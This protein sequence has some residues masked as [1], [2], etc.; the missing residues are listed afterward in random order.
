VLWKFI[1]VNSNDLSHIG[2]LA[3]AS[4]KKLEFVLNKPGAAS[5]SYPMNAD[6][7]A[8]IQPFKT[9]IKAMR[10]NRLASMIA[11]QAVWDC[12]WSGYVMPIDE[13]VDANKM[14]VSCVGWLNRL[15]KRLTRREMIFNA[16]DDGE[17][18]RQL[19]AEMNLTTAPDGYNVPIP[20][21]SSPNTPT[22]LSW[23]G[24]QPNE[25]AG[26]ATAYTTAS[27]NKTVA[28]YTPV[29]SV[30]DELCNIENGG[31]IV[32]DPLTR[33]VTWHRRY[34]RVKD[35]VV[36]GFQW[37]PQ[38][39][40]AFSRNIE[41]DSQINYIVVYGAPGTTPQYMDDKPQQSEIGL[42]E[43]NVS[44]ADVKD[45]NVLLAYAGAEI[46][47]RSNGH[48]TYSVTPFPEQENKRTNVVE[49]LNDFR[50]GDQ[51]RLTGVHPPRVNIRGQ[52]VRV[53]GFGIDID[54]NGVGTP[55]PL[56]VA[57]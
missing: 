48:I 38:N 9:G 33:V 11:G 32:V 22:W 47:V 57:P 35:D 10:Y 49:P 43:E 34:R 53:F 50:I 15:A 54:D 5:F 42:L 1:L 8:L 36:L 29:L 3:H 27:R 25:G 12:M 26:G 46:I 17:I 14:A 2:E 39:V 7:A 6:Y 16:L 56:Q 30:I 44:L 51:C 52:A 19:L 20:A 31:D 41:T 21:G 55:T 18:V 4:G 40:R 23:G 45:N 28:K 13:S 24:T 37:G